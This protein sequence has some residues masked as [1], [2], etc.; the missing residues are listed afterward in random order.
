[1]DQRIGLH[2]VEQVGPVAAR[3]RHLILRGSRSQRLVGGIEGLLKLIDFGLQRDQLL[4]RHFVLAKFLDGVRN[5]V[6][7]DQ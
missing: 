3:F 2:L 6:R 4:P 1:M 7:I 5:V